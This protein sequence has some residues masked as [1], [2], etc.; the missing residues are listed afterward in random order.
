[1]DISIEKLDTELNNM[2]C[3]L[4]IDYNISDEVADRIIN[5]FKRNVGS[6][7]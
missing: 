2:F 6:E 5:K 4:C 7:K 1:M 3:Q